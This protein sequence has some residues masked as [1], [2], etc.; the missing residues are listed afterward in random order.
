MALALPPWDLIITG[1]SIN[2]LEISSAK[3]PL[4]PLVVILVITPFLICSIKGLCTLLR[5]LDANVKFLIPSLA[6]ASTT[7]FKT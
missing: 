1:S 3:P 5:E 4:K 6:M 2:P 7:M